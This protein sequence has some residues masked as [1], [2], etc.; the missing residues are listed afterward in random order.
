MI[1][2]TSASGATRLR[3]LSVLQLLLVSVMFLPS[4]LGWSY[5]SPLRYYI[6]ISG[7]VLLCGLSFYRQRLHNRISSERS[8]QAREDY[9]R[10]M[11][12]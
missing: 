7:L 10:G 11:K 6:Q 2:F 1:T 12:T 3:W 4:L 8:R 5:P 9:R